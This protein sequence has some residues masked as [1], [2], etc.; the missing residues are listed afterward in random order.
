MKVTNFFRKEN[1]IISRSSPAICGTTERELII[2][3]NKKNET[4]K[5]LRARGHVIIGTSDTGIKTSTIKI[6][7]LISPS[8]L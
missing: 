5:K 4:I 6:W 7:F 2:P 8:L 3:Y 1:D